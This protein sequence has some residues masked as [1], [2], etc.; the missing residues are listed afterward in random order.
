MHFVIIWKQKKMSQIPL[1][2]DKNNAEKLKQNG[3]ITPLYC[4]AL[5]NKILQHNQ[6]KKFLI[7]VLCTSGGAK[8]SG[9]D[10]LS[11]MNVRYS[12][13][14]KKL[15]ILLKM[16]RFSD[17]TAILPITDTM[18]ASRLVHRSQ[19]RNKLAV[20]LCFPRAGLEVLREFLK[21]AKTQKVSLPGLTIA[22]ALLVTAQRYLKKK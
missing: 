7:H 20:F 6:T 9:R 5:K 16:K 19:L 3:K 2:A 8:L 14:N 10:F 12:L 22:E 15:R 4:V 17:S 11:Q 13:R 21:T 18:D 1:H